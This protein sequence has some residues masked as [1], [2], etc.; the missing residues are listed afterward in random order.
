MKRTRHQY[1]YAVRCCKKNQLNIQ[2][3]KLAE[4]MSSSAN[5][6]KELKKISPAN[7]VTTNVMDNAHGDKNVMELLLTKYKTLNNSVPTSDDELQHLNCIID[8]G[9][10]DFKEQ[11]M[12]STPDLIH[13]SILQ[14]KKSK[15]DGNV[16]FK[17]DH[18][19][20]GGHCLHVFLSILFNV[21]ITHGY[22]AR[23]L[24]ISSILSIPKDMKSSLTSSDNYR[25]ISLFNSI[26]KVFDYTIL[27]LCNDYF[28]TS[29]MQFGF[30]NKHST[31]MC[32]VAYYEV[33]NHYL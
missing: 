13:K 7:K 19:I 30:K 6:W 31:I 15:D 28:M 24:R 2:K 27:D 22:N 25:G 12:F 11:G 1:H 9:I 20:N 33:I 21:M 32:S 23:D 29:D 17:S 18:F 4:N 8:N 26:C 16:G 10:S 5:F 3:Q 14:L